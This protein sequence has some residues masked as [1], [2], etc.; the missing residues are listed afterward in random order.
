MFTPFRV[1]LVVLLL[2]PF[3]TRAQSPAPSSG[4]SPDTSRSA[5]HVRLPRLTVTATRAPTAPSEA[6]ARIT[7]LDSAAL[8][9]TGATSVAG[10][11][12]ARAGLHIRRY[13]AGGLATPSLRG[14]GGAQTLVLLDG[15]RISNPQT[16]VLDL[17]LLPTVLLESVEVLH[18]AASPLYG[19][20]GMGGAVHL[21][22]L[23]PDR[24]L[25]VR[26]ASHVGAFGERGG[27]VLVGSQQ[28]AG[29]VIAAVELRRTDGDFP[30]TDPALFPPRTVHRQNADRERLSLYTAAET[31]LGAHDLRIAGWYTAAERGLPPGSAPTA[32]G[33]RQWDNHL[34]L[35]ARDA[36]TTSWGTL[37]LRSLVQ[38]ASIRY[39]N[40]SVS[41]DQTG[42]TLLG[43]LEAQARALLSTR[44][45]AT[46]G[47]SGRAARADHPRLAAD[48][49]EQRFSAFASGTG[50]Y[51]RLTLY[52]ALRVDA[53]L[54]S[55]TASVAAFSPRVGANVQPL[56]THPWLHV[57]VHA[58]R[59]F[60]APTFNDRYWQPGGS[61]D[62]DPE[63]GW[64][65]DASLRADGPRG[66]AEVTAFGTWLHDQIVWRPVG[67]DVWSPANVRR[68][69][70]L[71]LEAAAEWRWP[72]SGT[73]ALTT[74]MAYTLS[75]ARNRSDPASAAF[76]EPLRHTPRHTI[77]LY[78]TAAVGPVALDL[79]ARSVGR[80]YVTTD[81]SSSLDPFLVLDAQV[82]VR[83][84]VPA[85]RTTLTAAVDNVLDTEYR[86]VGNRPMPPRHLRARLQVAF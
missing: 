75:D 5:W 85:V 45:L 70:T 67:N 69:R 18:G 76:N 66:F 21:R 81:G 13:G 47:L 79:N 31:E 37:T 57:K 56:P 4:A 27:S 68:T 11:L 46:G 17:S 14:T 65:L 40:P 83:L 26:A 9:R 41:V 52:P 59:A 54:R 80:R 22:T 38:R 32:T 44:W 51:G 29:S 71:G 15:A 48:A 24:P 49:A 19:S 28:P 77:N 73:A 78:G 36:V 72:L 84:P 74:G 53:Y 1:S 61:P 55:A 2:V 86:V 12:E 30:Y 63:H 10:L 7:V 35:W 23:R 3:G 64:S 42:T 82:R 8:Q 43:A 60:R 39:R 16:G 62:L 25:Q 58:G 50:D 34:R 20:D 33:E 6:P